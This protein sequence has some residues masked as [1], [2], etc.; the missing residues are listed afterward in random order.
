MIC[1]LHGE[2]MSDRSSG[3]EWARLRDVTLV[4]EESAPVDFTGLDT[5]VPP[6]SARGQRVMGG[7][8]LARSTQQNGVDS[9][10]NLVLKS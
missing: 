2:I 9:G 8:I 1:R 3:T 10:F 5:S 6:R 7:V 4:V